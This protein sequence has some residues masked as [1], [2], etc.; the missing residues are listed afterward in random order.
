LGEPTPENVQTALAE[1]QSKNPQYKILQNAELKKPKYTGLF[2]E[3]LDQG[4]DI[5]FEADYLPV[6]YKLSTKAQRK[7]A[8]EV[9][10]KAGMEPSSIDRFIENLK[11]TDYQSRPMVKDLSWEYDSE[12]RKTVAKR[13]AFEES[14]TLPKK[15]RD[16]L[17]DAGLVE[18]NASAVLTS[19]FFKCR[20][21]YW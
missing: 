13:E 5:N 2:Q 6:S 14:R 9:L 18:D 7:L 21:S 17:F 3:L 15:A 16:A 8:K 12:G 20:K 10:I 11:D 19:H 4:I 1:V